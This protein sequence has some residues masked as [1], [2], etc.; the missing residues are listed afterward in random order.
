[1]PRIRRAR[2]Q[3]L[4]CRLSAG[5][6]SDETLHFD[7][8][9]WQEPTLQH[10]HAYAAFGQTGQTLVVLRRLPHDSSISVLLCRGSADGGGGGVADRLRVLVADV[11]VA[12]ANLRCRLLTPVDGTADSWVDL[13]TLA[14][15]P[16]RDVAGAPAMASDRHG[17][18]LLVRDLKLKLQSWRTDACEFCFICADRLRYTSEADFPTVLRLQEMLQRFPE[19]VERR[20]LSF[21]DA[22]RGAYAKTYLAVSH[23][24]A[25]VPPLESSC[26]PLCT[27]AADAAL[28]ACRACA[29]VQV[30]GQHEPRYDG[31]AAACVAHPLA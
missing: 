6:A 10:D 26:G 16:E 29:C 4:V 3:P 31:G 8:L 9:I 18:S 12:Y 1:M 25:P 15:A 17:R 21:G 27:G 30:G 22:C 28:S 20:T 23:R 11:L 2:L 24:C 13:D 14:A 19:W 5:G 7:P